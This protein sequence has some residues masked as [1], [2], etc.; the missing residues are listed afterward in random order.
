MVGK[1][2]VGRSLTGSSWYDITPNTVMPSMMSVVVIGR[3]MKSAAKFMIP[4]WRARR[5]AALT[6]LPGTSRRW[7]SVTT[8]SPAARPSLIT[9]SAPATRATVD[10]PQLHGLI[11]LDEVDVGAV[12]AGLH[13][14]RRHDDRR[15][16]GRQPHHDVDE[17]AGP[18]L[19]I[20]VGERPLDLDRA[21]RL[22]DGVV[23][24]RDVADGRAAR[25]RSAGRAST[26]S[27]AARHVAPQRPA[28]T[29][30]G[31]R[32]RRRSA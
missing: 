24:E 30:R 9:V 21:G 1:S 31:T 23:D 2:T 14:Q 11:R 4:P 26:R 7:P 32:T 20:V 27:D 22:I 16:F 12:R 18:E 19:P 10:R 3:L 29:L 15:R 28:A 5:R 17:L 8:V 6:R 13:G 25:R